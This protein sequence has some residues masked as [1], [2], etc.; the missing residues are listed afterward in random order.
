MKKGLLVAM[1]VVLVAMLSGSAFAANS[2]Q[3]GKFG[4]SVGFSNLSQ[5]PGGLENI[6]IGRMMLTSGLGL[7]VGVGYQKADSDPNPNLPPDGT[8]VS[9]V[10]GIRKY[11]KVD[12][13]APFVEGDLVYMTQD[14]TNLD[15]AGILVNAGAEYFLHKQFSLEGSV[16]VG[17]LQVETN[18]GLNADSTVLGTSSLGVRAN[19]YF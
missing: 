15:T 13:F 7:N 6:I 10:L 1:V 16:G 8:D 11:L 17:L 18:T 19:F 9:L 4:L 12:D 5:F 14:S 2:I 3:Q